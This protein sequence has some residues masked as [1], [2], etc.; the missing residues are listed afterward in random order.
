MAGVQLP[1]FHVLDI[2]WEWLKDVCDLPCCFR[3]ER[4]I[5]DFF[6]STVALA[7]LESETVRLS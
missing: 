5:R 4:I 3:Q 1:V 7:I 6:I 2:M